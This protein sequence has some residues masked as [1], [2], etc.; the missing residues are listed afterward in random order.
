M[1]VKDLEIIQKVLGLSQEDRLEVLSYVEHIS[2]VRS[3]NANV[4]HHEQGLREIQQALNTEL[5]F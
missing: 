3:I 2:K 4:Q 5:S 1:N